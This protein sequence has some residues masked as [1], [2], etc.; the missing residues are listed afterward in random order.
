[1]LA[2]LFFGVLSQYGFTLSVF[3]AWLRL[4]LAGK[5]KFAISWWER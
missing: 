2:T 5:R 4:M 1:L 3:G